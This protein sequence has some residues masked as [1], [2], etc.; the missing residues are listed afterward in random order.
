MVLRATRPGELP[1]VVL[2]P[3]RSGFSVPELLA[4]LKVPCSL[5]VER[6][7]S[8]HPSSFCAIGGF[9]T[10]FHIDRQLQGVHELNSYPAFFT[11]GVPTP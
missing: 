8:L 11:L 9:D 5:H 3:N 10:R 6:K 1:V 4:L 7:L 2:W